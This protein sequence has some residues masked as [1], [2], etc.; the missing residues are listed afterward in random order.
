MLQCAKPNPKSRK[1]SYPLALPDLRR[2][3]TYTRVRKLRIQE[4]SKVVRE[5]L[6]LLQSVSAIDNNNRGGGSAAAASKKHESR[7]G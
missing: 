4:K 5:L 6:L 1:G 3:T 7:G 2:R